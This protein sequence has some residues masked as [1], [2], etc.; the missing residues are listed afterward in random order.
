MRAKWEHMKGIRNNFINGYIEYILDGKKMRAKW[1]H[2]YKAWQIDGTLGAFR[3]MP[4][5]ATA[6]VDPQFIKKM[7][8]SNCAQVLSR[9]VAVSINFMAITGASIESNEGRIYMPA[10]GTETTK[11]IHFCD[12]LFDSLNGSKQSD[13]KKLKCRV[14]NNTEH[15][16]FW[17]SAIK[18]L[19][20]VKFIMKKGS[21]IPPTIKNFIITLKNVMFLYQ[22]M[23]KLGFSY[24]PT[25]AFNQDCL[26]FFFGKVRKGVRF[27]N[28]TAAVFVPFYKSFFVNNFINRHSSGNSCEDDNNHILATVDKL[29]KQVCEIFPTLIRIY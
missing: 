24:M 7:K 12:E 15:I 29:V 2:I 8:V 19:E 25:R 13:A 10:E 16:E 23:K 18:I 26:E 20:T 3:T 14:S 22:H 17:R 6:H 9:S 1:E 21:T 4:K 27:T 5:L 28:P 11:F